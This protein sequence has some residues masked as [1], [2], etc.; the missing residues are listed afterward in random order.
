[1]TP[2]QW[3]SAVGTV[4]GVAAALVTALL[5]HKKQ[6]EDLVESQKGA[7]EL[8]LDGLSAKIE[9]ISE[10]VSVVKTVIGIHTNEMRISTAKMG[11]LSHELEKLEKAMPAIQKTLEHVLDFF[12]RAKAKK[13]EEKPLPGGNTVLKT[14]KETQG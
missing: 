7:N 10:Q 6:N 8:L 11:V 14:K 1:M 5:K 4:G 9:Q 3:V 13:L 2:D 12:E